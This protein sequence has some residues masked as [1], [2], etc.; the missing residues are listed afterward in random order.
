MKVHYK[1]MIK[2]NRFGSKYISVPKTTLSAEVHVAEVSDIRV[3]SRNSKTNSRQ[4]GKREFGN[5]V[6]LRREQYFNVITRPKG[7]VQF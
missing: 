2:R 6:N 3:C 7:V 4:K 1:N 5:K